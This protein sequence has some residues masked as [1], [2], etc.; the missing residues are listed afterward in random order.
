M[1]KAVKKDTKWAGVSKETKK[2]REEGAKKRKKIQKRTNSMKVKKVGR[3]RSQA[4]KKFAEYAEK[5][6]N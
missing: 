6:R 3:G 5:F 1:G 2:K 4:A